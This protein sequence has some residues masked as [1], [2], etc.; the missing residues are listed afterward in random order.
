MKKK[1]INFAAFGGLQVH[2]QYV[3]S[4][5]AEFRFPYSTVLL[6]VQEVYF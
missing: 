1:T 4:E 2:L 3:Y 5:N 6:L